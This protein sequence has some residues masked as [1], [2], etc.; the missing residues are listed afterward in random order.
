MRTSALAW[1][2]TRC[3]N[4]LQGSDRQECQRMSDCPVPLL[5]G[6][7]H[8]LLHLAGHFAAYK[9]TASLLL[10]QAPCL[11]ALYHLHRRHGK[12]LAFLRSWS[13][14]YY[15]RQPGGWQCAEE[16]PAPS[17]S[18]SYYRP[19]AAP[20]CWHHL[21]QPSCR[22]E[23]QLLGPRMQAAP[24]HGPL[25]LQPALRLAQSKTRDPPCSGGARVRSPRRPR[26]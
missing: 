24:R 21:K 7:S 11:P 15:V 9:A 2:G 6:G 17:S 8:S 10:Y 13:T 20:P 12:Q 25:V 1:T 14:Y 4:V 26:T 18:A 5:C 16:R 22:S 3:A 19:P 23:R